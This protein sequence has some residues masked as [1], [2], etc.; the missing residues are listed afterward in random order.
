MYG[1][2]EL[3][4]SFC[5]SGAVYGSTYMLR[6]SPLSVS[7]KAAEDDA[8]NLCVRAVVLSGEEHIGGIGDV[9]TEDTSKKEV[10]CNHVIT[11]TTMIP[12]NPT[13]TSKRVRIHRRISI[14]QGKII[15]QQESKD[16]TDTEQRYAIVIPPG[17]RGLNNTSA[18][19]GV[20]V[21]DSAFVAPTGKGFTVLHLTTSIVEEENASDSFCLDMLSESVQYLIK[22]QLSKDNGATDVATIECH[23]IAFS[24]STDLP[25]SSTEIAQKP[26]PSGLHICHHDIQSITCDYAFR[27]A[28]RI[29]ECICPGADFLALAKKVEDSIVYRNN[30]DSDDER[31][32]LS[33]ALDIIQINVDDKTQA[34]EESKES[35]IDDCKQDVSNED[36]AIEDQYKM[37]EVDA[38]TT[39]N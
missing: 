9:D 17:T 24:Y 37:A 36:S 28:K 1:S 31:M 25:P 32:V 7:V 20:A 27:E 2:G 14:M 19:H 34:N 39:N 38:T 8:E 22:S 18:I 21:D 23:H 29:F 10:V 35:T 4:Q 12:R 15:T 5:R 16:S 13:N 26:L 33:S 6:R 3:S 30:E 11:P